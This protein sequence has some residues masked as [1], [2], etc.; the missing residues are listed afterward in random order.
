MD[1]N[2]DRSM[3]DAVE[4][5]Q[6]VSSSSQEQ[7]SSTSSSTSPT[8]ERTSQMSTSQSTSAS[9]GRPPRGSPPSNMRQV[10]RE[11]RLAAFLEA[12]QRATDQ[13]RSSQ[14]IQEEIEAKRI[15]PRLTNLV[16]E[17]MRDLDATLATLGLDEENDD[18]VSSDVRVAQAPLYDPRR[19][20]DFTSVAS[21]F[22]TT[23]L[24]KEL[25]SACE[26]RQLAYSKP[27]S[28]PANIQTMLV[29]QASAAPTPK[30]A[31]RTSLSHVPSLMGT[32]EDE[33]G[34][35]D[36]SNSSQ[37]TSA[38][39]TSPT[40]PLKP[41]SKSGINRERRRLKILGYVFLVFAVILAI[42]NAKSK[43][44]ASRQSP[45]VSSSKEARATNHPTKTAKSSTSSTNPSNAKLHN[46]FEALVGDD[47]H[48]PG[49][50]QYLAAW[51]IMEKDPLRYRSTLER[52]EQRFLLACFYFATTNNCKEPWASCNFELAHSLSSKGIEG[53]R[54]DQ[55]N[56]S[57][58][59][60]PPKICE[61]QHPIYDEDG[62]ISEHETIY[63]SRWLSGLSECSWAG[64]KCKL[65]ETEH[66][67]HDQNLPTNPVVES[68]LEGQVKFETVVTEIWQ[69]PD[70][71][72]LN[73]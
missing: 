43:S 52:L 11:R 49:S 41:P 44:T 64:I 29:Q 20:S 57:D 28:S 24:Q 3:E 69:L 71:E 65:K 36:S 58:Q 63:T 35:T 70:L 6:T 56:T 55:G 10:A 5:L 53:L 34:T 42:L 62:D 54:S 4:S 33:E 40:P 13:Q 32:E 17:T 38:S 21:Q 26:P 66:W 51:W 15:A 72:S 19:D 14:S 1:D 68:N 39:N 7:E 45:L 9:S 48:T 2:L 23:A 12:N 8:G 16:G 59:P 47:I 50:S 25:N 27:P 67:S 37:A 22:S 46:S 31:G 60:A 61:F 18:S 30:A 73:Y